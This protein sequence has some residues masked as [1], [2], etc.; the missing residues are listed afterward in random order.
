MGDL[1]ETKNNHETVYQHLHSFFFP[2]I[3]FWTIAKTIKDIK[4]FEMSTG[5]YHIKEMEKTLFSSIWK[6]FCEWI[7]GDFLHRDLI[8]D[9]NDLDLYMWKAK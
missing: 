2:V 5:V 3:P 1:L 8:V 9:S 6:E 7:Q 4:D